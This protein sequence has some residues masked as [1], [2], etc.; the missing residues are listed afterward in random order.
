MRCAIHYHRAAVVGQ[1]VRSSNWLLKI[2]APS[3]DLLQGCQQGTLVIKRKG[4]RLGWMA[5][6]IS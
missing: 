3:S 5:Y 2:K 4:Y 6:H 1:R